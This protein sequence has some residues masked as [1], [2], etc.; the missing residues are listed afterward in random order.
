MQA[1]TV[2]IQNRNASDNPQVTL[3]DLESR[4]NAKGTAW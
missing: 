2:F 4:L 1:N 3:S